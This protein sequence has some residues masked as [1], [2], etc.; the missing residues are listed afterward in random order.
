MFGASRFLV[1]A[2]ICL[3]AAIGVMPAHAISLMD[4]FNLPGTLDGGVTRTGQDVAYGEGP[5][6]KL[7]VYAPSDL[8]GE[9]PVMVFLYG[10]AWKQGSKS[11]Y[12]FVGHAFA[13]QGFV[14]V[15]PD[16]R[17][18][19]DARYP[20]FIEDNADA[21][22]WVEDNIHLF[23]GDPDRVF[24]SGHSAGAYN[25]VMLGMDPAYLDQAGVTIPIRGVVGLSGPY[26]VYPFEF[27]ELQDAFG[28][29]DNPQMTQP[30]N[31]SPERS[32]PMFLAHGSSDLIVSAANTTAM[33][34]KFLKA[35][36]GISAKVY[37]G[38]GH[39]ETVGA[40]AGIYRWRGSVLDDVMSF[41]NQQGAFDP[42]SFGPIDLVPEQAPVSAEASPPDDPPA[43]GEIDQPAQPQ[44]SASETA[45][46]VDEAL[47]GDAAGS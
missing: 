8:E 27:K 44:Q 19:P 22:K 38:L 34:D 18:V 37:D 40:L 43:E 36:H 7:D 32:V 9:A 21:V 25:A 3:M 26:A 20:T 11:D 10:G 1:H 6:H 13:A 16:Y 39:M 2:S 15:I 23:G 29:V 42:E 45:R 17:L 5:R 46:Q 35:N 28:H 30:I 12:P 31:L 4:P 24:L 33:R 47:G 14:T 41:L